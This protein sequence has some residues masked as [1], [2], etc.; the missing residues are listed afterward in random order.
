MTKI[1][2]VLWLVPISENKNLRT[3]RPSRALLIFVVLI[4]VIASCS[5]KHILRATTQDECNLHVPIMALPTL[6]AS[7]LS[8]FLPT[9]HFCALGQRLST[10]NPPPRGSRTL[11]VHPILTL[12]L[13]AYSPTIHSS[14]QAPP[15]SP[16]LEAITRSSAH[17]FKL[18]LWLVEEG[19]TIASIRISF[20][21]LSFTSVFLS[22]FGDRPVEPLSTQSRLIW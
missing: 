8:L 1:P 4:G 21:P 6:S 14:S 2:C 22:A 9:S 13:C 3:K 17:V 19:T 5:T 18:A 12:T 15:R 7:F 16:L 20:L 11:L 10:Q